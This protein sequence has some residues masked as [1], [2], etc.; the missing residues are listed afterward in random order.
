MAQWN[1]NSTISLGVVWAWALQVADQAPGL[2]D[3]A[4]AGTV[5]D[6][7]GVFDVPIRAHVVHQRDEAVVEHGEVAAQYFF[8]G[9]DG[10]TFGF[11]GLWIRLALRQ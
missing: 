8:G 11:H 3:P 9:G 10:G 1:L 4:R 6:A 7:G 5:A 2:A